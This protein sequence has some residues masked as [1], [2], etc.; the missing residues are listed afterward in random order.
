MR[1][2]NVFDR[3]FIILLHTNK[4]A[5]NQKR[6]LEKGKDRINEFKDAYAR[7]D[8]NVSRSTSVR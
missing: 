1:T 4:F 5:T 8:R 2:F 6:T 3:S 7:D